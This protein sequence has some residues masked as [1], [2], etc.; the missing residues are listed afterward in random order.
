MTMSR[1]RECP[2]RGAGQQ[3]GDQGGSWQEEGY[4]IERSA[5]AS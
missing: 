2:R 4:P 5:A 1:V 3:R